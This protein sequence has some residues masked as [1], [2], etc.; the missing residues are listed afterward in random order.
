MCVFAC[1]MLRAVSCVCDCVVYIYILLGVGVNP[2]INLDILVI[3]IENEKNYQSRCNYNLSFII[4]SSWDL[5]VL[6]DI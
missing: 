1:N 3:L 2:N 6:R 4:Y 5:H